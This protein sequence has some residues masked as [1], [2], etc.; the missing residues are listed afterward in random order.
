M[1]V[2]DMAHIV[3]LSSWQ[4]HRVQPI[5]VGV[6]LCKNDSLKDSESFK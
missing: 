3:L 1:N 6:I 2:W 5:H 4:G